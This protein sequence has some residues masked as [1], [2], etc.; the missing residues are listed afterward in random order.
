ME[1]LKEDKIQMEVYSKN[2]AYKW[3][4]VGV[5]NDI[6]L[7]NISILLMIGYAIFALGT[8]HPNGI[9]IISGGVG[10]FC[11]LLAYWS[12]IGIC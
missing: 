7:V 3:L 10:L 8:C 6:G 11:C 2:M 1:S 5:E 9:K 12:S 4:Y